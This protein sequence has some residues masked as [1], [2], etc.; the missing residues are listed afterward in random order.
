MRIAPGIHRIGDS[1]L[2]NAYLVEDAGEVTVIDAGM[3]G[4]YDDIPRELAAMG[5]RI[6]DVRALVLTHGHT[7][8]LGFAERLRSERDIR[9]LIHELDAPL[10]LGT[11][12]EGAKPMGAVR[13]GPL[14][15]FLWY[16]VRHGGLRPPPRLQLAATFE[17]GATLD[18]PGAPRVVHLP[19]HTA[20]SAALH[21]P[22]ADALFI[23]DAIATYAVT[24]GARGP[25]I[26]P[27]TADR[28]Q[29]LSS[30]DRLEGVEAR[31]VLPG[32]GEPWT[33]GVAAAV[34]RVRE[35]EARRR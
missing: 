5:R 32:H 25:H 17:D 22:G 26:A 27:F 28:S 16:A 15:D 11:G 10:A 6:E 12:K 19:G 35:I 1:P 34:Q 2:V 9:A 21:V 30:L 29:A 8:H 20:G 24:N 18:V 14:L 7:D 23:G 33:D 4:G 13:L 3:P 31:W